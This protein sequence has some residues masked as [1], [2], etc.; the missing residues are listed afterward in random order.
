VAKVLTEGLDT[1][2]LSA[3]W[4]ILIG[5]MVGVALPLIEFM[6]PRKARRYMPSAMGLGLAW[7]VPFANT[8]AFA[9]GAVVVWMWELVN[10]RNSD[11]YAIPIASGLIAGESLLKAIIAMSATAIGLLESKQ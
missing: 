10:R 1:L 2:A 7:V 4:S 9:I 6:L 11:R 3:K 8:F 5:A